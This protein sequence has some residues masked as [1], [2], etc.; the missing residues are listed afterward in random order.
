M[1][2]VDPV[3]S[4]KAPDELKAVYDSLSKTHGRVPN[5]FAAMAHRPGALKAFLP[6]YAT[7]MREGTVDELD[8]V[9]PDHAEHENAETG[10]RDANRRP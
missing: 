5:F 6:L 8:Q 4:E 9:D 2:V 10:R 1:A 7:V 3:P